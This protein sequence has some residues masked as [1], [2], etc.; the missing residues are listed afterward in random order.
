MLGDDGGGAGAELRA[1]WRDFEAAQ[2]PEARL[3]RELDV[4]EMT[5]QAR[6]YA[7][8][9]VLRPADAEPF[10]ASARERVHSATGLALLAAATSA[11]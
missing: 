6:R 9:G 8:G 3:V 7:R 11:R 2:T 10:I 1:L 5:A 4:I